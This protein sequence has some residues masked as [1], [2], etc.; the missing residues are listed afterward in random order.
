MTPDATL[1][2][3]IEVT[4]PG[5]SPQTSVT[6]SDVGETALVQT[7][8]TTAT[9][10]Y[11]ISVSGVAGTTG[12]FTIQAILNAAIEEE[13]LGGVDN[14]TLGT[15]QDLAAAF[16][17]LGTTSSGERAAVLGRT[18]LGIPP[19][20]EATLIEEDTLFY[21][22]VLIFDFGGA[23]PPSGDG[24]LT[25]SVIA[26]LGSSSERLNISAEGIDF[27]QFFSSGSSDYPLVPSVVVID[28]SQS[29]LLQLAADGTI[30]FSVAPTSTV[31]AFGPE[32]IELVLEYPGPSVAAGDMYEVDLA[33]GQSISVLLTTPYDP[34]DNGDPPPAPPTVE[35]LDA[36]GDVLM[37]GYH[38]GGTLDAA[39]IGYVARTTGP[40]YLRVVGETEVDYSL[41]VTRDAVFDVEPN[42]DLASAVD[43]NFGTSPAT[44]LGAIESGDAD[45]DYY[46]F[47][48]L[49]GGQL[50]LKT[51]TPGGDV[52]SSPVNDLDPV[53]ELYGPGGALLA[54]D[55]N[56]LDGRNA[57]LA[58]P[59]GGDP[60]AAGV[61][62][63]RVSGFGTTSGDY[64]LEASGDLGPV[65]PLVVASSDPAD[66]SRV[67]FSPE[68]IT[69]DFSHPIMDPNNILASI[70]TVD[71][72][73]ADSVTVDDHDTLRFGVSAVAR[74]THDVVIGAGALTDIRD[75]PV[76]A[77]AG[78][79]VF[80]WPR[81]TEVILNGYSG[82]GLSNVTGGERGIETIEVHFSQP[83][84]FDETFVELDKVIFSGGEV[85]V[86]DD[87][88]VTGSGT[89]TMHIQFS[90]GD[91]VDTWLRVTLPSDQFD[92]LDGEATG[93]GRDY[94][95]D[96]LDLPSGDG[97]AGGNA[98]FYVGSLVGNITATGDVPGTD[99]VVDGV[100]LAMILAHWNVAGTSVPADLDHSGVVG[101]GD[102][103][104][105]VSGGGISELE[106]LPVTGGD[107]AS[108]ILPEPLATTS[109]TAVDAVFAVQP[110]LS[111]IGPVIDQQPTADISVRRL[112]DIP[113][114]RRR[115]ATIAVFE[116][117]NDGDS[118]LREMGLPRRER[119]G[120]R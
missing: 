100:D 64:T 11:T 104:V 17:S 57:H 67:S 108:T 74:G 61:Y 70:L 37:T 106:S 84:A 25:V 75:Q 91:V 24:T 27:G 68:E 109:A 56:T 32:Y 60:L 101:V 10:T 18:E 82:N 8:A 78:Q 73:P 80:E 120:R 5:G 4:S 48:M 13:S 58:Y 45:G 7:F 29:Q 49:A 38:V 43:L 34:A 41:V 111:V 28:I 6:A 92:G 89:D 103:A 52:S 98:I 102:L 96:S 31:D 30:S 71:G 12:M 9:G 117:W 23:I 54:S 36:A 42:N 53:L 40:H 69:I 81:V 107:P 15:A 77:Y 118:Q 14:A 26:D 55:D 88:I 72:V 2:P 119:A 94:L 3:M 21:P 115:V 19:L 39:I 51:A 66:G 33:A 65:D 79:F 47:T 63:V 44:A 22:N 46:R 62:T 114:R 116:E 93:S 35:L 99:V 76:A 50:D 113:S 85:D 97:I 87:A 16:V 110:T 95:Y 59:G 83:I 90:P 20:Y 105:L 86:T 1:R 112:S